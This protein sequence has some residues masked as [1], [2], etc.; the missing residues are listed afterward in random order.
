MKI[1][2]LH[3]SYHYLQHCVYNTGGWEGTYKSNATKQKEHEQ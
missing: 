3:L 2:C 1:L